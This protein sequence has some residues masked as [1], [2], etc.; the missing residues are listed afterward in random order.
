MSCP[1]RGR[2]RLFLVRRKKRGGSA[3]LISIRSPMQRA[4]R[5]QSFIRTPSRS[6]TQLMSACNSPPS[7]RGAIRPDSNRTGVKDFPRLRA[8]EDKGEHHGN[9]WILFSLG[10]F[11]QCF[12]ANLPMKKGGGGNRTR[13]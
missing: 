5:S 12:L 2:Q 8:L 11:P 6:R 3:S 10:L 4:R 9:Q 1:E 7:R 13:E